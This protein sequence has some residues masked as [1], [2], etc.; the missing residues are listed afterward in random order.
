M[1]EPRKLYWDS[2]CFISF[3]NADEESRRL[4]CEDILT[5]ARNNAVEIWTSTYTIAEVVRPQRQGKAPLP[6]WAVKAIEA[7][8]EEFPDA[9]NELETLWRRYQPSDP[10]MRLTATE[11]DQISQMFEWEYIKKIN[12]SELVA[13]EAV[14]LARDYG[15]KPADSIHAASAITKK[16]DVLQKWDRDFD[17]VSHLISVEEPKMISVQLP[18]FALLDTLNA[19][20]PEDLQDAKA[21]E[22]EPKT[23]V[24]ITTGLSGSGNGLASSETSAAPAEAAQDVQQKESGDD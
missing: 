20:K 10:A 13:K 8:E 14:K 21:G 6:A 7:I 23:S 15:L 4:I 5:H 22:T 17:R 24:T 1:S 2:S 9:R 19:S 11:T 18:I 12:V 3:L 16:V